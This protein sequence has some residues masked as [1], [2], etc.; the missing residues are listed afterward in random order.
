MKEIFG[1]SEELQNTYEFWMPG[2]LIPDDLYPSIYTQIDKIIGD[3]SNSVVFDNRKITAIVPQMT[4]FTPFHEGVRIALDYVLSHKELQ[5]EDP[6]FDA[7]CDRV[8]SAQEDA[9]TAVYSSFS[10][11]ATA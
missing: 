7:W 4:T 5:V 1:D 2:R 10:S 6:E 8:I 11:S 9:K 3:K